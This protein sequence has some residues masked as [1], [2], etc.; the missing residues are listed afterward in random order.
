MHNRDKDNKV[1][2]QAERIS[3]SIEEVATMHGLHAKT[4]RR[5]IDRG[6]LRVMRFGA[7][8][9]I[10]KSEIERIEQGAHAVGAPPTPPLT[11]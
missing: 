4:I 10:P 9:R 8:I 2:I 1:P 3:F 11:P 5:M 6:E 7:S